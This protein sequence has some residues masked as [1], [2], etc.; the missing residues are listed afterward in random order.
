[1]LTRYRPV[2]YFCQFRPIRFR[3][4]DFRVIHPL[5]AVV[6]STPVPL[7]NNVRVG[8]VSIG[9][10]DGTA[11]TGTILRSV[12]IIC[13][14][15]VDLLRGQGSRRRERIPVCE[16]DIKASL[17]VTA[18]IE[19]FPA[20]L[21]RFGADERVP[22]TEDPRVRKVASRFLVWPPRGC[23]RRDHWISRFGTLTGNIEVAAFRLRDSGTEDPARRGS[24]T[25]LQHQI[26]MSL[27]A[28]N[29]ERRRGSVPQKSD[30]LKTRLVPS[31]IAI[32]ILWTSIRS[33]K[34]ARQTPKWAQGVNTM[35][36]PNWDDVCTDQGNETRSGR[37]Q[38]ANEMRGL[39]H[40]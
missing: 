37:V 19:Q 9:V 12:N 13:I 6:P 14:I 36:Q 24:N 2:L 31:M 38:R 27:P 33:S 10:Q 22:G 8:G 28:R 20:P 23:K 17:S 29:P 4:L 7:L 40:H 35:A 39:V 34:R 32:G 11:Q 21:I 3:M 26:L 5:K 18:P 25:D 1:M 16:G 15:Y 30:E